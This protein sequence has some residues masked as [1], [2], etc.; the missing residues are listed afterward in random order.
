MRGPV[1]EG[2][3]TRS[4]AA[5]KNDLRNGTGTGAGISMRKTRAMRHTEKG[6]GVITG[7]ENHHSKAKKVNK[8]LKN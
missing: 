1:L 4:T 3:P 2:L 6:D 8:V 5:N 7:G